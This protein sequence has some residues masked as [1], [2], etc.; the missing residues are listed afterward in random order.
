MKHSP[1]PWQ[2]KR[3]PPDH[4]MPAQII[5]QVHP[6]TGHRGH[7]CNMFVQDDRRDTTEHANA[8]LIAAAPELLEAL[9]EI[10]KLIDADILVRSIDG[11]QAV[12]QRTLN[13]IALLT[14]A[15][16]KA[17]GNIPRESTSQACAL[18][19]RGE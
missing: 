17:T 13:A 10:G 8:R 12:G 4:P 1:G 6:E 15:I 11:N 14:L 5:G 7:I 19:E 9:Q 16:A 2:L 3:N 18:M